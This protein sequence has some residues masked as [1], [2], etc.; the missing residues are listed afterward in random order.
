MNIF[1]NTSIFI[2]DLD[3][4]CTCKLCLGVL[5]KPVQC[6]QGHIYCESCFHRWLRTNKKSC[7][8]CKEKITMKALSRNRH[9]ENIISNLQVR[10]THGDDKI[11]D[12][13]KRRKTKNGDECC[14]WKGKH[15][16]L[17]NHLTNECMFE[18][19]SCPNRAIGCETKLP[20][21]PVAME[22]HI[23]LT[24]PAVCPHCK[25]KVRVDRMKVHTASCDYGRSSLSKRAM[26]S[27]MFEERSESTQGCV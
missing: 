20:R 7:P 9:L 10:C 22:E 15:S 26:R 24:C 4:F 17:L 16:E 18:L 5:N 23:R 27:K 25:Q 1:E 3:E 12:E 21:D 8:T 14:D 2:D 13:T 6:K 11:V 19:V